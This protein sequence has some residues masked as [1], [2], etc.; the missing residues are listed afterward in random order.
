LRAA[1]SFPPANSMIA[2]ALQQIFKWMRWLF[3]FLIGLNPD[4]ISKIRFWSIKRLIWAKNVVNYID[5]WFRSWKVLFY[6]AKKL[7]IWSKNVTNRAKNIII[8][9]KSTIIWAIKVGDLGQNR[10]NLGHR[11]G[12]KTTKFRAKNVYLPST[13][14]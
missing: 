8:W 6:W 5:I 12:P 3:C 1:Y 11:F 14:Q 4:T 9:S 7:R 2:Y 13:A 10:N